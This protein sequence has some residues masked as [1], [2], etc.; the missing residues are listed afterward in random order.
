MYSRRN[1]EY[2]QKFSIITSGPDYK[3]S[4]HFTLKEFACN[5]GADEVIVHIAII[6]LL[7]EIRTHFKMPVS[8]TS[9]YRTPSYNKQING[10]PN[11][12][13][14]KGMAADI[15]VI[16]IMPPDVA[17]FVETLNPGGLGRYGGFTHIDVFGENRRWRR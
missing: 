5:D 7:E 6:L 15:R 4:N 2:A 12:T 3:L 1:P 10:S 14:M 9:G 8:I 16:N 13:H 17:N 11:S